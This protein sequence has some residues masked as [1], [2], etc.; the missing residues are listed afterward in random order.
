MDTFSSCKSIVQI[1]T[2]SYP[3]HEHD[4]DDGESPCGRYGLDVFA[5]QYNGV[6]GLDH[7]T[8]LFDALNEQTDIDNRHE[9]GTASYRP[10]S[11]VSE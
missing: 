4:D 9:Y 7:Q 2:I 8:S 3:I 11:E 6:E 10:A 1:R 5:D